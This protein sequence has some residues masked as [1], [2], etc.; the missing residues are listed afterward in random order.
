MLVAPAG[1]QCG[2]HSTDPTV[3]ESWSHVPRDTDCAREWGF[4]EPLSV[5]QRVGQQRQHSALC[6][7]PQLPSLLPPIAKR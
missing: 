4:P 7:G 5:G 3:P 1:H 2:Y 6:M